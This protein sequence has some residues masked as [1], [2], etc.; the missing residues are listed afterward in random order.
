MTEYVIELYDTFNTK[1]C[2]DELIFGDFND[3]PF[4]SNYYNF[5]NDDDDNGNNIPDNP[6]KNDLPDNKGMEDGV[7]PNDEYIND[8]IITDEDDS[9]VSDINLLQNEM[10]GMEGVANEHERSEI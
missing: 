3:Q 1:Q 7:V 2:S 8:E 5:L 9:L 4:P 10:M 6:I